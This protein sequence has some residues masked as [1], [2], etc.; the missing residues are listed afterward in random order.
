MVQLKP[1]HVIFGLHV[2]SLIHAANQMFKFG[3]DENLF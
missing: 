3:G 2:N 1:Y